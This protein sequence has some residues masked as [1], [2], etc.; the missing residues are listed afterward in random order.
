MARVLVTRAAD[1]AAETASLLMARGHQPVIA[2]LR[3]VER[4]VA[5]LDGPLPER[6]VV[7]SQ[8]ALTGLAVPI[9]WWN[10]PLVA[11]GKATAIAASEAGFTCVT[12]AAGDAHSVAA[13]V[14]AQ[15]LS[16]QPVLFLSGQPRKPHF[17]AILDA[18][19]QPVRV[20]ETYRMVEN[21]HFAEAVAHALKNGGVDA[22]LH[23]SAESASAYVAALGLAGSLAHSATARHIVLSEDVA[24]PLLAAGIA[25]RQIT[26]A[27]RPDQLALLDALGLALEP[28][29]TRP[30]A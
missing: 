26:I 6:I 15:G 25:D 11:V 19:G 12:D 21:P 24:Q 2:P 3:R 4:L 10:I 27:K 18:A 29:S 7:T 1:Q 14:L 16:P 17:E 22:S 23:F 28:A 5:G 30:S 20:I 8:N 9:A 13:V